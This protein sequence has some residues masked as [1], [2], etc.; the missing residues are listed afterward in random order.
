M[1]NRELALAL[2]RADSESEVIRLL[3]EARYWDDPAAWRLLGDKD[4]NYST[5]G[6]QQARP[7][8]ALVEKIINSVDARLMDKCLERGID[9][10]SSQAPN[11]IP[12]AISVLFDGRE[13]SAMTEGAIEDWTQRE[14]LE[15][16]RHI[17][18]AITGN[19][20]SQGKPCVTI[21]D[22]GEG[23]SPALFPDTF[24]SIDK[25]NKLRIPFV[26]GKFNMGGT[27]VLKFCGKH[28]L[29]LIISRRNPR[30]IDVPDS[31]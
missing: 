8:A 24:M 14:V 19:K 13:H 6:N 31:P 11:S 2:L 9:P 25:A 29:Q 21:A 7:E 3:K 26:Q 20:P 30:I 28:S 18:V 22:S 17:T 10:E 1:D 16:A 4:G 15:Q 27:G 5:V 23:Q 12:H